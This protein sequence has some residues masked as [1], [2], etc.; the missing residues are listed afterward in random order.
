[1]SRFPKLSG[2]EIVNILVRQFNFETTRQTGGHMILRKFVNEKKI[3]TVIP[4]H[5]QL[6]LKLTI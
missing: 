3:V 2:K 5:K 1:M 4:L 6:I